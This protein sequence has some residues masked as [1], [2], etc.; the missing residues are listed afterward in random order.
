M[1]KS[2]EEMVFKAAIMNELYS[3]VHMAVGAPVNFMMSTKKL[4][5]TKQYKYSI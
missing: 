4:H 1:L 5:F 3:C 2:A